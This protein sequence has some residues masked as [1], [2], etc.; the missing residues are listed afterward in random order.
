MALDVKVNIELSK[1]TGNV[2]FGVPLLA[3]T[4]TQTPV[5]YT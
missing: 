3:I 4:N 5:Q 1:A 2:G